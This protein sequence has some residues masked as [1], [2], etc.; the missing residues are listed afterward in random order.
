MIRAYIELSNTLTWVANRHMDLNTRT[1]SAST[2][3]ALGCATQR[4]IGRLSKCPKHTPSLPTQYPFGSPATTY[5]SLSPAK[6]QRAKG[7]AFACR[8]LRAGLKLRLISCAIE[9]KPKA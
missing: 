8:Y 6:G 5:G 2:K 7:I 4:F 9:P 3:P 1:K